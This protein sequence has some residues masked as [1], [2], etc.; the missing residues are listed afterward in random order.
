MAGMVSVRDVVTLHPETVAKA[1]KKVKKPQRK[2]KKEVP[3]IRRHFKKRPESV[4][5]ALWAVA[6]TL[7]EG[8]PK[9]MK[10]ES[11][12]SILVTNK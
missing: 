6:L 3:E 9:R 10:I 1:E 4:P 11:D 8:D 7:A 12:Y 2:A 5:Q